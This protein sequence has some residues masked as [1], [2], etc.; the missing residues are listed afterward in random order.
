M[1]GK[2]ARWDQLPDCCKNC[3]HRDV[4]LAAEAVLSA[5]QIAITVPVIKKIKFRFNKPVPKKFDC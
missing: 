2:Y 5:S 1:K 4:R 3:K